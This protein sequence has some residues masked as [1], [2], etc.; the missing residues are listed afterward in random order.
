MRWVRKITMVGYYSGTVAI[1]GL[2]PIEHAA[3]LVL[4]NLFPFPLAPA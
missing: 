2:L 1:D 3:V 4:K